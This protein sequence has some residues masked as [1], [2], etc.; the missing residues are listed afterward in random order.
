MAQIYI[1]FADTPGLFAWMIRKVLKQK[2]IHEVLSLDPDLEEAYSVGRRHPSI[3]LIA[4]FEREDTAKV[5]RAFPEADYNE[6]SIESTREQKRYIERELKEAMRR[7]FQYH[8]A[9]I[10]LPFIL[11]NRPFYQKNHYTCSSYIARLLQDAGIVNWE[12]HFSLVTPKDFYEYEKK[13]TIFEGSLYEFTERLKAKKAC[14]GAAYLV[15]MQAVLRVQPAYA[16]YVREAGDR[17]DTYE[18]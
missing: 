2:Y 6:C 1:A 14:R 3:P 7:R 17:R 8:Y 5:L 16:G 9:V 4:G 18:R 13:E 11:L 15:R 10:G 12:K